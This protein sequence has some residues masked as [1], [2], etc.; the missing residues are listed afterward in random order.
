MFE[1]YKTYINKPSL[2]YET[3]KEEDLI[4]DEDIPQFIEKKIKSA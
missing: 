2:T 1:N 3:A 4:T